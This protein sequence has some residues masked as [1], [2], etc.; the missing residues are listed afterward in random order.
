MPIEIQEYDLPDRILYSNSGLNDRSLIWIPEKTSIVLGASNQ[1]ETSA[2][3]DELKADSIP[4][5]KRPS[6][7]ETVLISPRTIVIAGISKSVL[8]N[9]KK[10][11]R[12]FNDLVINSLLKLGVKRVGHSGISDIT[13]GDKKLVGSAVYHS[14][15]R[16]FYHAVL[17]YGESPDQIGRYIKHPEREPDY[18]QGRE[19]SRFITSLEQEGYKIPITLLR[20]HLKKTFVV[21]A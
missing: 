3:I 8:R 16:L 17:N 6:G 2:H 19:H 10:H 14:R 12:R 15:D 4:V 9:V 18:R 7:G 20:D 5:Y 21:T 1:L 11:F 13:I